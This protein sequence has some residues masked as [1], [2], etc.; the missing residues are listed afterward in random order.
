MADYKQSCTDNLIEIQSDVQTKHDIMTSLQTLF[1]EDFDFKTIEIGNFIKKL[2]NIIQAYHGDQLSFIARDIVILFSHLIFLFPEQIKYKSLSKILL[3]IKFEEGYSL[4]DHPLTNICPPLVEVIENIDY[5][6][7]FPSPNIGPFNES[8]DIYTELTQHFTPLEL[9]TFGYI[10]SQIEFED[11]F[12]F[13]TKLSIFELIESFPVLFDY[14]FEWYFQEEDFPTY[15]AG[16]ESPM[17]K[18]TEMRILIDIL[19]EDI[20]QNRILR[21]LFFLETVYINYITELPDFFPDL[22]NSI[23]KQF[24][25][26]DLFPISY[27]YYN[28]P[29]KKARKSLLLLLEHYN[30]SCSSKGQ[31]KN[32]IYFLSQEYIR[33]EIKRNFQKCKLVGNLLLRSIDYFI[34]NL[35]ENDISEDDLNFLATIW[36]SIEESCIAEDIYNLIMENDELWH[37]LFYITEEVTENYEDQ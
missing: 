34:G 11:E 2:K 25:Y 15:I 3:H 27:I 28:F 21:T 32:E 26:Q 12:F 31:I 10:G 17:F 29:M 6:F 33:L 19:E 37:L 20:I 24:N 18:I 35:N 23:L 14:I 30:F 1:P 7:Q 22:L 5:S 13:L 9:S 8:T 4:E 16:I 36:Y